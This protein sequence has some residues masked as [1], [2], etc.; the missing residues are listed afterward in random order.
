MVVKFR[1]EPQLTQLSESS[2]AELVRELVAEQFGP[3]K[4]LTYPDL[5]LTVRTYRA[6]RDKM[7]IG[8]RVVGNSKRYLP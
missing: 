1:I 7:A 8:D 2:E 4:A 5:D 3:F 6:E